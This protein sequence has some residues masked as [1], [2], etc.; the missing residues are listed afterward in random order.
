SSPIPSSTTAI[1]ASEATAPLTG[2]TKPWLFHIVMMFA[3]L[4]LAMLLTNWGDQSKYVAA[5]LAFLARPVCLP[6]RPLAPPS[7]RAS[8]TPPRARARAHAH[9]HVHVCVCV[10]CYASVTSPCRI[11]QESGSTERSLSSMWVRIVS[12]WIVYA[13]YTWTLFAAKCCPNRDFS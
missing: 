10:F 8:R 6:R 9:A 2:D 7:A 4:Y 3:G 1:S 11:S 5:C 12:Q 13:L